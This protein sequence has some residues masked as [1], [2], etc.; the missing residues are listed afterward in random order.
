[1][2]SVDSVLLSL[3][4]SSPTASVPKHLLPSPPPLH[5]PS[6]QALDPLACRKQPGSSPPA[7]CPRSGQV[8]AI[9]CRPNSLP[10][11]PQHPLPCP[12]LPNHKASPKH[13]PA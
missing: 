9:Y 13:T 1:M 4:L 8:A 11:Q 3:L 2:Q 7:Q 12:P 5:P 10:P 6:K